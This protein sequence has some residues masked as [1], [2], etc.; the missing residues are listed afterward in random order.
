MHART[1]APSLAFRRKIQAF[2]HSVP[3]NR[4][5]FSRMSG[6]LLLD[7]KEVERAVLESRAA[8]EAF[9]VFL[10]LSRVLHP[11]SLHAQW[12]QVELGLLHMGMLISKEESDL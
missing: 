11:L 12:A 9:D 3:A 1:P 5:P 10:Q 7:S 4:S 2:S 8:R 6:V